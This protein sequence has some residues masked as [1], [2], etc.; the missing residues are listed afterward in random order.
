M[1]CDC[2]KYEEKM[3][4]DIFKRALLSYLA[5]GSKD[6]AELL[7]IAKLRKVL[8]KVHNRIGVWL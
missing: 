7:R 4:R 6:I 5:D 3:D 8:Q 2:L 1:I